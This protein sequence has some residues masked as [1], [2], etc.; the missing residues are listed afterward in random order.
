[1]ALVARLVLV[2][3]LAAVAASAQSAD[4]PVVPEVFQVLELPLT[5]TNPVLTPAKNGYVLKCSLA[6]TSDYR[7]LG[8]RYSLAVIDTDPRIIA[9][10]SE[11]F[12][13]APD[14]IKIVTFRT[15]LKSNLKGNERLVLMVE[16]LVTTDYV[17]EVLQ[18]KE[19]L[20]NYADGDY[21][22]TP[23]VLRVL[24]QVDSPVQVR[25]PF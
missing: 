1:M 9:T 8:F 2:L 3:V 17:W 22:T 6:N 18:A 15:P 19:A 24:N 10:R 20:T 14:E 21:S 5:V 16:Q 12:R 13:L 4:V 11:G 25:M 23:H 7:A